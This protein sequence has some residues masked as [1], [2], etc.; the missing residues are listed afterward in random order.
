MDIKQV[1]FKMPKY[2]PFNKPWISSLDRN[3]ILDALI[4]GHLSGDGKYT[5]KSSKYLKDKLKTKDV[6]ITHSCT[7][8]L[9]MSAL[10]SKVRP[11]D[12]VIL[13][14]YTFVSTANAFV[15][16]G[17]VPVFVDIDNQTLNI[18]VNKVE[19]AITSK[20][21]LIVPVHYAGVSC[22]M[23]KIMAIADKYNLLVVEDAAQAYGS[24]YK[25]K[26]LGT[27]GH[28]G[29]LSFHATKNVISGEGGAL[30]VNKRKF[31]EAAEIIREKGTN[32]KKFLSGQVDKYTWQSIGSSF[33]PSELITSFL[34][35]QLEN[36]EYIEATRLSIW[37]NYF[38]LTKDLEN[39]GYIKRPFIPN[40]CKHNGHM[41]YLILR[42]DINREKVINECKKLG[43]NITFHYIPLHS[44]PAGK[45][46]GR[47]YSNLNN[48]VSLSK[49]IIR[50]PLWIGLTLEEQE[51]IITSLSSILKEI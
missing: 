10:I 22:D 31:I 35:G 24:R 18:D 40:Y 21:K 37:N 3:N 8:A 44:S 9:E 50:L 7:A 2:I 16:R 4:D 17:A 28:L 47:Y 32:R 1:C 51:R 41:F 34:F 33:L 38:Q 12:E 23:D 45:K 13:P 14:S 29:T 36:S 6:L 46:Y 49:R 27:I 19:E 25:N 30:L 48:T 42:E 5:L 11:G 20:T 39:Q 43:I 15:L 26:S